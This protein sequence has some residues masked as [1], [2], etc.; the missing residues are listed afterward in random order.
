MSTYRRR[1]GAS[2]VMKLELPKRMAI[3]THYS[4]MELEQSNPRS[5]SLSTAIGSLFPRPR[6]TAM[7]GAPV[8]VVEQERASRHEHQF[9]FS[10]HGSMDG[11]KFRPASKSPPHLGPPDSTSPQTPWPIQYPSPVRHPRRHRAPCPLLLRQSPAP[12][13][14]NGA[15]ETCGACG[16]RSPWHL[17]VLRTEIGSVLERTD[18]MEVCVALASLGRRSNKVR[19]QRMRDLGRLETLADPPM[20]PCHRHLQP[21]LADKRLDQGLDFN[22]TTPMQRNTDQDR[23]T[24]HLP[25]CVGHE[26]KTNRC[27]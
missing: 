11:T 26:P 5:V 12:R 18:G 1:D 2:D 14:R 24:R 6:A 27:S 7:D 17:T 20:L 16:R 21:V 3:S 22:T 4:R 23:F 19:D 9:Q 10:K 8:S 13:A 15:A 25:A